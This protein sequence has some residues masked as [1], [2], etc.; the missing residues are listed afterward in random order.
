MSNDA[1]S[2]NRETVRRL[3]EDLFVRGQAEI[4]DVLMS[5]DYVNHD[6]SL[7]EDRP[8]KTSQEPRRAFMTNWSRSALRSIESPVRAIW[9]PSKDPSSAC[10]LQESAPRSRCRSSFGWRTVESPNAGS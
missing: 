2:A 1:L 3:Y 7:V 5:E 9:S 4:S 8:E 6:P 10:H